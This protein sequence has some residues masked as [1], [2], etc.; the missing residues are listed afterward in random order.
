M[1]GPSP[2]LLLVC[3]CGFT[4]QFFAPTP[5]QAEVAVVKEEVTFASAS[6]VDGGAQV[7]GELRIPKTESEKVPAVVVI[8]D[9]GG[10]ESRV[11]E[12]Y[13]GLL[14]QAG[15]ATLELDLFPR[16]GRP[17]TSRMNLPH[18]YGSLIYLANHP[19][20]DATRI[21]VMGFSWGG[22]LSLFSTSSELTQAYT[23][24]KYRFA[25]HMPMYPVCWAHLS[26]LEGK[27]KVYPV[28]VYQALTGAPVHILAAEKDD[29]DDPDS[30]QKFVQALPE[31]RRKFVTVTLTRVSVTPGI[32]RP[33]G[34]SMMPRASRGEEGK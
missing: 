13:I 1:I 5:A 32:R 25:A 11:G 14:N 4:L 7:K 17:P 34:A 29:Y 2:H 19:R 9:S 26:V 27:N 16:G 18:T 30:C 22:L 10:L 28:T 3:A 20:I 8:H 15:I 12:Q 6:L 31:A 33:I 23:G 21:G 24:G